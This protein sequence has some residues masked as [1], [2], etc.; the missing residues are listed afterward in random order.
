MKSKILERLESV[1]SDTGTAT[2]GD[3][4]KV[5]K[6]LVIWCYQILVLLAWIFKITSGGKKMHHISYW[7]HNN[8]QLWP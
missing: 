4:S 3:E 6:R 7:Q 1:T 8:I 2:S 5:R